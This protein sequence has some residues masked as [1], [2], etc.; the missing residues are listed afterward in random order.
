[1]SLP[2]Y[3]AMN[4]Q[5]KLRPSGDSNPIAEPAKMHVARV[6]LPDTWKKLTFSGS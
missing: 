5:E 4:D 1:M 2:L 6:Q 3:Q